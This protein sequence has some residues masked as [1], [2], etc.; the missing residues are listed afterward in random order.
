MKM[1][2][3]NIIYSKVSVINRGIEV[4]PLISKNMLIFYSKGGI[5]EKYERQAM[6]PTLRNYKIGLTKRNTV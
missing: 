2:I 5:D 1:K 6:H 3:N 4:K